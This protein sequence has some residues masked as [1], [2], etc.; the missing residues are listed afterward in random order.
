MTELAHITRVAVPRDLFEQGHVL[1]QKIGVDEVE[2]L[3]LWAGTIEGD[4]VRIDAVL[5]PAQ[6][7]VRTEGGLLVLVDGPEL[8]RIGVWLYQRR[9]Q[10]VAQIHT[11]PADAYHSPTDDAIPIVTTEGGLSLVVP[12]FARGDA[13]IDTYAAYRL[14]GAG[15]YRELSGAE[16]RGLISIVAPSRD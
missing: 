16:A 6:R 15:E 8:H 7:A 1:L 5:Y 10:L 4:T 2:G 13:R 3:I 11:H 14:N 12:D 9:L